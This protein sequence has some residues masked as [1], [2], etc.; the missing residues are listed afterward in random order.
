M[1]QGG[2]KA[3]KQIVPKEGISHLALY[4]GNEFYPLIYYTHTPKA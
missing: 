3:T 2:Q 4:L 1:A